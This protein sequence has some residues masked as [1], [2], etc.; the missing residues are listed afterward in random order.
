[1]DSMLFDTIL[2]FAPVIGFLLLMTFYTQFAQ[3]LKYSVMAGL[4]GIGVVANIVL[5]F[6]LAERSWVLTLVQVVLSGLLF[7]LFIYFGGKKASSDTVLTLTGAFATVPLFEGIWTVVFGLI[8]LTVFLVGQMVKKMGGK[9]AIQQ[10]AVEAVT[11]GSTALGGTPDVVFENLP[12]R[13]EIN[14]EEKRFSTA[15]FFF[16]ASLVNLLIILAIRAF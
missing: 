9:E 4:V 15:P 10:L 14:S 13:R 16:V 12:D 1:M 5:G 8:F 6:T 3:R 2:G 11:S 7:F